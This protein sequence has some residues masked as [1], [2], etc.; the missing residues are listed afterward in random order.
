MQTTKEE[1][2]EMALCNWCGDEDKT[3][4]WKSHVCIEEKEGK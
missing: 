3:D 2:K 1:G 4:A